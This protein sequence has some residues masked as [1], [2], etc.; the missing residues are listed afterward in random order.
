MNFAGQKSAAMIL[1]GIHVAR[2]KNCGR[3]ERPILEEGQGSWKSP[4]TEIRRGVISRES[5]HQGASHA[6][7]NLESTYLV[8]AN[9]LTSNYRSMHTTDSPTDG[10][11]TGNLYGT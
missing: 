11:A 9:V 10:K 3:A 8:W 4:Q 2:K 1:R 7:D 5:G 6:F